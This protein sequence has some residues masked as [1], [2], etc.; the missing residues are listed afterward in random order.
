[1]QNQSREK[2][3]LNLA[4]QSGGAHGAFTWGVLDYLLEDERIDVEGISG[5]G[6]GAINGSLLAYGLSTGDRAKAKELLESFWKKISISAD[7]LNP[8][9]VDKFFSGM[10][11]M[12]PGYMAMDYMMRMMSPYQF[13]FFN[14]N[15]LK[16]VL[17]EL[18]DFNRLSRENKKKLF[19]NAT[20]VKTSK[21]KIFAG[22]DLTIEALL[23]SACLPYLY[24]SV[25]INGEHYWDGSYSANP[26]LYP[27]IRRCESSDILLVQVNPMG[28]DDVPRT[29]QD[30]MD[31]INEISF[32]RAL[33]DSMRMI[34]FINHM[35]EKNALSHKDYKYVFMHAIDA[36][37]MMRGLGNASKLN[38]DW[39]FLT[40]MRDAGRQAAEEWL[41]THYENIAVRSTVDIHDRYIRN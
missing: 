28:A 22:K 29:S 41:R 32:N 12:A 36:E 19:I 17:E 20:N 24:K 11:F 6:A 34:S 26:S 15:P 39:Q 33:I 4:L 27:L 21:S 35:I 7:I 16:D 9:M 40:H 37:D 8:S 38:A 14:L 30:I 1:M 31:R 5:A 25:E 23:A 2:K 13:N 3:T 18:I 10:D